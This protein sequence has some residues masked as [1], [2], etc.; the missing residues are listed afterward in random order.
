MDGLLADSSIEEC[1]GREDLY[2][3]FGLKPWAEAVD[4]LWEEKEE[5]KMVMT[6]IRFGRKM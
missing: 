2:N 5:D 4:E 1:F 3:V 6:R